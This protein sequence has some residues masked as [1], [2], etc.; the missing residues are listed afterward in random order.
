[1]FKMQ[2]PNSVC[3]RNIPMKFCSSDED[4]VAEVYIVIK[5]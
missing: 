3:C 4:F 5:I 1:M 2:Y